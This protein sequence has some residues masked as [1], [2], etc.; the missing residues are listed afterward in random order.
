LFRVQR[1]ERRNRA[2][3]DGDLRIC[4]DIERYSQFIQ[5]RD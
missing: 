4:L 5:T 1:R 2:R 3:S